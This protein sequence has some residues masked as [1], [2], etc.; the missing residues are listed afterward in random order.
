M[1]IAKASKAAAALMLLS[2]CIFIWHWYN[3]SEPPSHARSAPAPGPR[4][5]AG[6]AKRPERIPLRAS[7]Q[8]STAPASEHTRPPGSLIQNDSERDQTLRSAL[9]EVQSIN[10]LS[11]NEKEKLAA[12]LANPEAAAILARIIDLQQPQAAADAEAPRTGA[13]REH[14]NNGGNL[15]E[16][17]RSFA[18]D[19]AGSELPE[20]PYASAAAGIEKQEHDSSP[21]FSQTSQAG[22]ADWSGSRLLPDAVNS[23]PP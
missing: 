22:A 16:T 3:G 19:A 11:S 15:R 6:G 8:E 14:N 4:L 23:R 9:N 13:A 5:V 18:R 1:V 10:N 2:C 7:H 17:F 20:D 12:V 21:Y